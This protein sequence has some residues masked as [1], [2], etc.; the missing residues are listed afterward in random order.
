MTSGRIN[1]WRNLTEVP[2]VDAGGRRGRAWLPFFFSR[3][4]SSRLH[5]AAPFSAGIDKG[6]WAIAIYFIVGSGTVGANEVKAGDCLKEL[7]DTGLVLTV[8]TAPCGEPHKGEIFAVMTMP[9]G[10]FPGQSAI[11]KYQNKCAPELAKYSP[12]AASD[13]EIGLFVLYPSEDS[14]G[15][16]DRTVTCIATSETPRTGTLKD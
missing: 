5:P 7:P 16:G 9:D 11:E 10:D 13:P 12:E 4:L 3:L 2:G 1:E 14:W 15:E 6:L 8:D